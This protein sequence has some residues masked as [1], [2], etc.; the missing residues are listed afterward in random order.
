M[1]PGECGCGR[2]P[3]K[4]WPCS[5][6]EQ[7]RI[8]NSTSS[9]PFQLAVSVTGGLTAS[10]QEDRQDKGVESGVEGQMPDGAVLGLIK[11]IITDG[12]AERGRIWG[13]QSDY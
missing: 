13:L 5:E 6:G 9:L 10:I 3:G 7:R 1:K 11:R 12:G 8:I 2:W 4:K